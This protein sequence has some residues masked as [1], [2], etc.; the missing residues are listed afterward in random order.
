MVGGELCTNTLWCETYTDRTIISDNSGVTFVEKAPIPVL[1]KGHCAV[2]L[3]D[4][5]IMVIGGYR[6]P[7][8]YANTYFFDLVGNSWE[9]GPPL[10]VARSYHTCNLITDCDGNQQV[11][12]VGGVGNGGITSY[13]KSVEIYDVT[14]EA[15]SSGN[16]YPIA[17]YEHGSADYSDSFVVVGGY[18]SSGSINSIYL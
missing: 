13:E 10:T 11:V 18:S 7:I 9:E 8:S 12:V 5:T 17:V 6:Y 15:W 1:L 16:D 14:S 3:N 2:F 4:S